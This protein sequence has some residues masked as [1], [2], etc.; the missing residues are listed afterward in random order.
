MNLVEPIN[1]NASL[2][3]YRKCWDFQLI[4]PMYYSNEKQGL[5]LDSHTYFYQVSLVDDDRTIK[6]ELKADD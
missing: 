2:D 4:N 5:D 3:Q 6:F 1:L